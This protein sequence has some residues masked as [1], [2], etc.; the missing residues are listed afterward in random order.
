MKTKPIS[1]ATATAV[2]AAGVEEEHL[3]VLRLSVEPPPDMAARE[4]ARAE[5]RE[6]LGVG[7]DTAVLVTLGRLVRRKGVAWFVAQ[8]LPHA[9]RD[10]VHLVAG[11][12][13]AEDEDYQGVI[14]GGGGGR[15]EGLLSLLRWESGVGGGNDGHGDMMA[16]CP[17]RVSISESAFTSVYL[18]LNLR[19]L[20]IFGARPLVF[21]W[22]AVGQDVM[23]LASPSSCLC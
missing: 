18:L 3:T 9:R 21:R 22:C 19:I 6:R 15:E 17:S 1:N 13:P 5:L 11:A 16:I 14:A 10:V 23:T 2:R 12:G 4:Q 8:V 7:P 20:D